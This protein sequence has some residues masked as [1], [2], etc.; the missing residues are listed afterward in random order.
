MNGVSSSARLF[1]QGLSTFNAGIYSATLP[2]TFTPTLQNVN[3]MDETKRRLKSILNSDFLSTVNGNPG[4]PVKLVRCLLAVDENEYWKYLLK[5]IR[6]AP[7]PGNRISFLH[8]AI[9]G[10]RNNRQPAG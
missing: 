2:P 6:A 8:F 9:D 3:T 4:G 7:F 5:A 1:S 10:S